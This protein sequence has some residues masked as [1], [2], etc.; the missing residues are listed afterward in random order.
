MNRV[1][2][3]FAQAAV[4]GATTAH[5]IASHITTM[6]QPGTSRVANYVPE[7]IQNLGDVSPAVVATGTVLG[8]AAGV[9]NRISEM[10]SEKAAKNEAEAAAARRAD[11]KARQE[12]GAAARQ[13]SLGRQLNQ[14][15]PNK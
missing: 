3:K 10:N 12:A 2:K 6:A 13:A 9:G 7:M 11:R 15:K 4:T 14:N 1:V 5:V 8:F